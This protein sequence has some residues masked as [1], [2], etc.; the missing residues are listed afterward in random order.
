[1]NVLSAFMQRFQVGIAYVNYTSEFVPNVK[2]LNL[3]LR[4]TVHFNPCLIYSCYDSRR[5]DSVLRS[6]TEPGA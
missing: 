2:L 6:S 3:L 4:D 1:M 5:T